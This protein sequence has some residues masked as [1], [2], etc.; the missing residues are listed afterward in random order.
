MTQDPFVSII[1]PLYN[2]EAYIQ[3]TIL[4]VMAQIYTNWELLVVDN[5]SVDRGAD[6][7]RQIQDDRV[8]LLKSPTKGPGVARN[9]GLTQARGE[10]ILFLD[11]DD[12]IEPEYLSG[13]LQC[14]EQNP[15]ADIVVGSW[16]EFIDGE[17]ESNTI[18]KH[19]YALGLPNSDL[20][21]GAFAF[22]PWAVHAALVKRTCFTPDHYWPESLDRYVAEDIAFWFKLVNQFVTV[23][24]NDAGALYRT[25]TP[26]C[27]NQNQDAARWFEGVHQAIL[28]NELTLKELGQ[29]CTPK[30]CEYAVMVYCGLYLRARRQG[31]QQIQ[32]AA[33][34]FG[35]QWMNRYFA[36]TQ[37]PRPQMVASRLLGLPL[38]TVL[39]DRYRQLRRRAA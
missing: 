35:Q 1:V 6:I 11:A 8:H 39:R 13:Q 7:V 18:I 36:S 22:A 33:I 32:A 27:R 31:N 17:S 26:A 9:L 37:S 34:E 20:R 24:S 14:A 10:W 3:Q 29:T 28:V 25:E 2:K 38:Y 23:Y 21:D 16:Q 15:Q 12:L 5:G 30:Q 19:P 4:S